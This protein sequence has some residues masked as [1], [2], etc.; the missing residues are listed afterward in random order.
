[1]VCASTPALASRHLSWGRRAARATFSL[2]RPPPHALGTPEARIKLRRCRG[3]RA[4]P[5]LCL[6]AR[7]T[8]VILMMTRSHAARTHVRVARG[9]ALVSGRS[10]NNNDDEKGPRPPPTRVFP[11]RCSVP[12]SSSASISACVSASARS[13]NDD[14]PRSA[15]MRAQSLRQARPPTVLK[16]LP[17]NFQGEEF[18]LSAHPGNPVLGAGP[19]LLLAVLLLCH[20]G[21][22]RL[23]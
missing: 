8:T 10:D 15:R 3:L 5:L 22:S 2:L 17:R 6:L 18:L 14:E 1:M 11:A 23:R 12:T 7:T 13:G 19:L 16:R 9:L 20:L 21:Q 4:I